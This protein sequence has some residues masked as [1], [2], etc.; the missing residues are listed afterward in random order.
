MGEFEVPGY[1]V[2]SSKPAPKGELKEC[3]K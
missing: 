3:K 2:V 1:P